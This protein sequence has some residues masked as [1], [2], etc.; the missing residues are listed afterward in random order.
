M[1]DIVFDTPHPS[2]G[3]VHSARRTYDALAVK[4]LTLTGAT[5]AAEQAVAEYENAATT[6]DDPVAEASAPLLAVLAL[7]SLIKAGVALRFELSKAADHRQTAI[8]AMQAQ[9]RRADAGDAVIGRLIWALT[10]GDDEATE[11]AVTAAVHHLLGP[12]RQIDQSIRAVEAY[13]VAKRAAAVA[14][15]ELVSVAA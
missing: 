7:D 11:A 4:P 2:K 14:S 5:Y 9:E 10:A 15:A 3:Q 1:S 13:I 6:E 8:H 12:A